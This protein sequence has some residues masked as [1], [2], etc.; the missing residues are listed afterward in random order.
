MENCRLKPSKASMSLVKMA[1]K[2]NKLAMSMISHRLRRGVAEY[3]NK[4]W[5]RRNSEWN[6][7]NQNCGIGGKSGRTRTGGIWSWIGWTRNGGIGDRRG[8]T[9]TWSIGAVGTGSGTWTG[10]GASRVGTGTA[11]SGGRSGGSGTGTAVTRAWSEGRGIGHHFIL[12]Y[13]KI[14]RGCNMIGL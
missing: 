6:L 5:N 10:V 2:Y 12:K 11:V 1:P 8:G 9:G 7:Q 14:P 4:S 3:I 13:L